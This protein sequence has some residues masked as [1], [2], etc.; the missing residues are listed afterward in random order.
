MDTITL[1]V[2]EAQEVRDALASQMAEVETTKTAAAKAEIPEKAA[3]DLVDELVKVALVSAEKK[4]ETVANL[5]DPQKVLSYVKK[6]VALYTEAK[7]KPDTGIRAPAKIGV[8]AKRE[9]APADTSKGRLKEA[10]DKFAS[11][12]L[13]QTK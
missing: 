3:S 2:K 7:G 6:A 13:A 5:R 8:S 4:A 9:D 11:R 1:T 12:V 10:E